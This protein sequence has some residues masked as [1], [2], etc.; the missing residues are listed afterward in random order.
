MVKNKKEEISDMITPEAYD[1]PEFKKGLVLKFTKATLKITKVD[2]KNKRTWAEHISLVD[3]K[4]GLS[5]YGHLVD[6]TGEAME[7]HGSPYC[8]ECEV[9]ITEEATRDG[10][11]KA[12]YR[13]ERTL[14]DGTEISDDPEE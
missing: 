3:Q 14:S 12:A 6:T 1:D 5:H 2:R 10:K 7:E 13:Q 11:T 4:I 8:T 9:P